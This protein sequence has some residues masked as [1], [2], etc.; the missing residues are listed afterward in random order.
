MRPVVSLLFIAGG[1]VPAVIRAQTMTIAQYNPRSSLV[2]PGH[3]VTR[4]RFPFIDVH[5]HHRNLSPAR[6][7]IGRAHV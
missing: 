4:A 2:V 5:S 3:P 7:E 1:L 6:V